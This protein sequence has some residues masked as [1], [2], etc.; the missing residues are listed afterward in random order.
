[1]MDTRGGERGVDERWMKRCLQTPLQ[2][3]AALTDGHPCAYVRPRPDGARE[4][5]NGHDDISAHVAWKVPS[6][7][8]LSSDGNVPA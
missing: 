4:P 7:L 3:A 6:G 5:T 1:M 2:V 8:L